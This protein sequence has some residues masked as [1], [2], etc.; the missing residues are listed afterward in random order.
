MRADPTFEHP[1]KPKGGMSMTK[2][3]IRSLRSMFAEWPRYSATDS[4]L[5]G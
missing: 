5:L 4:C 3:I 2:P 1:A